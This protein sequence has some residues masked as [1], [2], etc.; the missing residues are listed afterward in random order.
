[1]L[2]VES[3]RIFHDLAMGETAATIFHDLAMGETAATGA[4]RRWNAEGAGMPPLP[5][6]RKN[7]GR[8][9]KREEKRATP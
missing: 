6:H 5:N 8:R 9:H 3:L 1:M 4:K 7:K 2:L